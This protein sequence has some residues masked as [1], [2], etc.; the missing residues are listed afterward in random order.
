MS[1]VPASKGNMIASES[2]RPWEMGDSFLCLDL[3]AAEGGR[4]REAWAPRKMMPRAEAMSLNSRSRKSKFWRVCQG[5]RGE[6]SVAFVPLTALAL[7][8]AVM[9]AM[10]GIQERFLMNV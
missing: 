10:A 6:V 5:V 1:I 2:S 4:R 9:L 8:P 7:K 3:G